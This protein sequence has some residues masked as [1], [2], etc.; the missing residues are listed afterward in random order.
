LPAFGFNRDRPMP[1][2]RL[3][4]DLNS[5]IWDTALA[6]AEGLGRLNTPAARAAL[7]QGLGS[8]SG[9]TRN[10]A[11]LAIRDAQWQEAVPALV[12][13]ILKPANA[14]NRG[15]LVYALE[16]MD[17]SQHFSFLFRLAL[18]GNLECR[19]HALGI[20]WNGGFRVS[21][22]E[23]EEARGLLQDHLASPARR[24]DDPLLFSDLAELLRG[25]AS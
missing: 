1:V 15:T 20:L 16:V 2:H 18:E 24:D 11:A 6:A 3:R 10:C 5:D 14:R 19:S 12:E 21:D 22:E 4:G 9:T 8:D 25:L 17:C 23:I 13:A 7:I